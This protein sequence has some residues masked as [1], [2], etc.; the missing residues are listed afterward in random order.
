MSDEQPV[1][2]TDLAIST[3]LA[4][5]ESEVADRGSAYWRGVQAPAKQARYLQLLKAKESGV[6]APKHDPHAD[7][8]LALEVLVA[9]KGSK[10]WR[11]PE[12]EALQQR[13]LQ[14]LEGGT[15]PDPAAGD[16]WRASPAAARASLDPALI[17]LAGL[18]SERP[19][20]G[21][22]PALARPFAV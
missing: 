9:N 14:I 12:A 2:S 1:P 13:Y 3:E 17:Q 8:R 16:A 4:E 15:S 19:G 11:G 10:Y 20:P 5:I 18:H 22:K 6:E 21:V 7:E